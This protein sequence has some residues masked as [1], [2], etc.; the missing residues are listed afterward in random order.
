M[1]IDGKALVKKLA[2]GKKSDREKTSLYLSKSIYKNFKKVCEGNGIAA[3]KVLEDL[4]SQF[5]ESIKK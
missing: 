3:S 4:I 2:T 1:G 5:I